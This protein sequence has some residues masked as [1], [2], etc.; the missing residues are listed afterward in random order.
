MHQGKY[1]ERYTNVKPATLPREIASLV[2]D[3]SLDNLVVVR[4]VAEQDGV[5]SQ[6]TAPQSSSTTRS[7]E[8]VFRCGVTQPFDSRGNL[9]Q[10]RL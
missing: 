5:Q 7:D 6:R 10:R 4:T 9:V 1:G 8:L 2:R 3:V